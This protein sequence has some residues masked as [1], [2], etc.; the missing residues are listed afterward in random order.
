MMPLA[1]IIGTKWNYSRSVLN[2]FL[3][4]F[5]QC[6]SVGSVGHLY[7]HHTLPFPHPCNTQLPYRTMSASKCFR[8]VLSYGKFSPCHS[9]TA[10]SHLSETI[11]LKC[12]VDY[13]PHSEIIYKYCYLD[14]QIGDFL[15][16]SFV[17]TFL[18]ILQSVHTLIMSNHHQPWS[19]T[20]IQICD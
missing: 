12:K 3:Q 7:R 20:L 15:S 5:Q 4:H 6:F 19:A 8:A 13:F 10:E 18:Q 9:S 1:G 16:Y 11:L 2:M 14:A 17:C